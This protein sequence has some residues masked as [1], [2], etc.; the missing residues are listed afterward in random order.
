MNKKPSFYMLIIA[1][2]AALIVTISAFRLAFYNV[3]SLAI[4]NGVPDQLAWLVPLIVEGSMVALAMA[5]L[6]T[7]LRQQ[8]ATLINWVMGIYIVVAIALNVGHTDL[9]GWAVFIA[10]LQ[11]VSLIVAFETALHLLQHEMTPATAERDRFLKTAVKLRHAIVKA[12]TERDKA[13]EDATYSDGMVTGLQ[14]R[15]A[16]LEQQRDNL[17]PVL[18]AY[19]EQVAQGVTPNGDFMTRYNVAESSLKRANGIFLTKN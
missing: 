2:L 16:T 7:I 12:R 11:P 18:V 4:E 6:V 14:H 15:L 10:T 9:T 8:R 1:T 13:I 5:R 3:Q 19:I 17:P